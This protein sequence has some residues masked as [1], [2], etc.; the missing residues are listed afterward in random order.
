MILAKDRSELVRYS[1]PRCSNRVKFKSVFLAALPGAL[2]YF[3]SVILTIANQPLTM[4]VRQSSG[5]TAKVAQ[6]SRLPVSCFSET[7][8]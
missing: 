6:L 7:A 1:A 4:R 8:W 2:V 5:T 3:F